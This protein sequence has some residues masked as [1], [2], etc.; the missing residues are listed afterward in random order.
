MEEH[1]HSQ[2]LIDIVH[3]RLEPMRLFIKMLAE[4]DDESKEWA[5]VILDTLY[6]KAIDEIDN[7]FEAIQKKTGKIVVTVKPGEKVQSD[8]VE[9]VPNSLEG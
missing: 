2:S 7:D 4:F 3:D 9:V 8:C 6:E 1:T 5:G